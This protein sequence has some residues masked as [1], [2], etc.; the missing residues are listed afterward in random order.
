MVG[1]KPGINVVGKGIEAN[2]H[3]GVL[4]RI[5]REEKLGPDHRRGWVLD[6]IVHERREPA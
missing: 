5:V 6:G 1:R 2:H 3:A 4:N